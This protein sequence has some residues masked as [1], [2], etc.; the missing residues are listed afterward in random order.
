VYRTEVDPNSPIHINYEWPLYYELNKNN[1]TYVMTE[2]KPSDRVELEKVDMDIGGYEDGEFF[3]DRRVYIPYVEPEQAAWTKENLAFSTR[4]PKAWTE[5]VLNQAKL[6]EYERYMR[7]I[8]DKGVG[9]SAI[10]LLAK[11][12]TIGP[13]EDGKLRME[14]NFN[15]D[16]YFP[17]YL[18]TTRTF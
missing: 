13:I 8:D 6:D 14:I 11:L 9:G 17:S 1:Q 3:V 5:K 10:N 2:P 18:R 4:Y 7:D 15:K 16:V 12:D